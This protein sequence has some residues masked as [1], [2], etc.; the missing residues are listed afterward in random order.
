MLLTVLQSR[1]RE[2][3]AAEPLLTDRPVLIEDK[4]NLVS[5]VETA[6]A[7]N[8]LAVVISPVSGAAGESQPKTAVNST[9]T[10][11]VVIHRSPL[12]TPDTPST[13]EVLQALRTRIHGA[14]IDGTHQAPPAAPRWRYVSWQLRELGDGSYARVLIC[15]ATAHV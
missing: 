6:L 8:S 5:T 11:E 12:D 1:L 13:V 7:T 14:T 3:V 9:E 4:N 15:S 10:F 2:I